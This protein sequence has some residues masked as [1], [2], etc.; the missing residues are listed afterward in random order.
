[1]RII[2][3]KIID[4]LDEITGLTVIEASI[5]TIGPEDI[6]A[7]LIYYPKIYDHNTTG[8]RAIELRIGIYAEAGEDE[9]IMDNIVKTVDEIIFG[10]G[11]QS[12]G[13]LTVDGVH[14]ILRISDDWQA[15]KLTEDQENPVHI[16]GLSYKILFSDI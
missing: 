13:M 12:S 10:D 9:S 3:D 15:P 1:M 16:R 7:A 8:I 2:K 6:P 4:M 14:N 11:F 5:N